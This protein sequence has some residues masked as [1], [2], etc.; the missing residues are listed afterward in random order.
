VVTSLQTG[1]AIVGATVTVGSASAVT[2]SAGT[3]TISG[4]A[5]GTY[6]AQ[7][8]ASGFATLTQGVVV[9]SGTTTTASFALP[10][11]ATDLTITLTWGARPADLDAHL[12]GPHVAGGR[13]HAYFLDPNPVGYASLTAQSRD[14]FGPEQIVIRRNPATGTYV[15]GEYHFWVRN[16]STTPGFNVSQARVIVNTS[17]QV[18]G[19]FDVGAATGDPSLDLWYVVNLQIDAA[20]NVTAVPQQRFTAGDS[21]V[22]LSPANGARRPEK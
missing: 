18:L 8:A 20:G 13:F 12:S 14:G 3:Y 15:A 1:D 11:S 19:T 2:G 7:A 9:T 4:V 10:T 21:F 17:T 22:V 6:L 16:F 5:P